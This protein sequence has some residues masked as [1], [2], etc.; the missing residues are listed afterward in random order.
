MSAMAPADLRILAVD[1]GQSAIRLRLSDGDATFEVDGVSR[2]EGSDE[3]FAAAVADAWR[4]AGRPA[5]DRVVLGMTTAPASPRR[6][7]ALASTVSGAIGANEVWVCD[8]AVTSHAGALSGGWGVSL[9]AGTGVACLTMP[10]AGGPRILGG[11][12]YLLGDEGGAFWIGREGLRAVLRGSEGRDAPTALT[13]VA[14][15]RFGDLGALPVR[16]HDDP[17][18]VNAIAQFAMDVLAAVDDPVA[19]SIVSQAAGELRGVITVAARHA[20]GDASTEPVPVALGGRLLTE[21]TP[22]RMALDRLLEHDTTIISRTAD[23]SPLDGA[24][25]LGRQATLG[26]YAPLVHDWHKEPAS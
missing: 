11:H 4:S 21:P 13:P 1:G 22:L 20:G 12:G 5:V 6:A 18:P 19:A 3:A 23:G 16:I 2:A 8:D 7:Q 15:D 24:M 17:R 10:A 26:R 9:V 25:W 14:I